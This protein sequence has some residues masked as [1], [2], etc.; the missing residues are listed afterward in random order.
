MRVICLADLHIV[1]EDSL[2]QVLAYVQQ[3][4]EEHRPDVIAVLGDLFENGTCCREFGSRLQEGT[5]DM[6][7]EWIWVFGNHDTYRSAGEGAG[8]DVFTGIFGSAQGVREKGGV[9]LVSLGDCEPTSGWEEFALQEAGPRTLFLS[10]MPLGQE[11]LEALAARGSGLAVS[12]HIHVLHRQ[13]ADGLTQYSLPPLR[14]GGFDQST[15]GYALIETDG[16]KTAFK[17]CSLRAPL[18]A[19]HSGRQAASA[20]TELGPDAGRHLPGEPDAWQHMRSLIR[21]EREWTGG[22]GRLQ[23]RRNGQLVWDRRYAPGQIDSVAPELV[24]HRGREYLLISGTWNRIKGVAGYYSFWAVDPESGEALYHVE[25]IGMSTQPTVRDGVAYIVSHWREM[26]AVE[27]ETGRELWRQRSQVETEETRDLSWY[28]GKMGAG[29]SACPPA[30]G[31]N[32]WAANSRGDLF[33]YDRETG[34]ELFAYPGVLPCGTLLD[35]TFSPTA[36]LAA[37]GFTEETGTGG[38]KVFG[39]GGVGVDDT[40]GRLME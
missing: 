4:V 9:R 38:E 30:V 25:T 19:S 24:E 16:E 12:G 10:H 7:G 2:C 11:R 35:T 27:L 40:T 13:Q 17:W 23:F 3:L 20:P 8:W 31:R 6:P 5:R 22:P 37:C 36:G 18:L 32:V 34:R 28:D 39:W 29:W 1:D 33:G 14:F 26:I 15:G 21:R